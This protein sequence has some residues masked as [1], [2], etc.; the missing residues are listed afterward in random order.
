MQH[1]PSSLDGLHEA[2][3]G[4]ASLCHWYAPDDLS[5]CVLVHSSEL[6]SRRH[7]KANKQKLHASYAS[8]CGGEL[9]A[10]HKKPGHKGLPAMHRKVCKQAMVDQK[11]ECTLLPLF[12]V[13]GQ[14]VRTW[15]LAPER[16]RATQGW[17]ESRTKGACAAV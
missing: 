15:R 9:N 4:M 2:P 16:S 13:Q 1:V 3:Q 12:G 10:L 5:I 7:P 11:A 6:I 17:A 8:A 14:L